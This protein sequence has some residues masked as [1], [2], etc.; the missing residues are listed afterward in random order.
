MLEQA[1]VPEVV[2]PLAQVGVNTR[3]RVRQAVELLDQAALLGHKDTAVRRETHRGRL[4]QPAHD[5]LLSKPRRQG[6]RL[7]ARRRQQNEQHTHHS[8]SQPSVHLTLLVSGTAAQPR[9]GRR[10]PTKAATL[11]RTAAGRRSFHDRP[12]E[13]P[14]CRP[15][16]E[17]GE[18]KKLYR[19][20]PSDYQELGGRLQRPTSGDRRRTGGRGRPPAGGAA[21]RPARPGGRVRPG[22]R[23]GGDRRDSPRAAA[24]SRASRRADGSGGQQWQRRDWQGQG[25]R[26]PRSRWPP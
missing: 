21:V 5:G 13:I 9:A 11:L 17:K 25:S 24:G 23:A 18:H 20:S 10:H 4:G 15:H 8:A 6:R 19:F 26:S 2:H 3:R 22:L 12:R 7:R 16:I 14:G 1:A